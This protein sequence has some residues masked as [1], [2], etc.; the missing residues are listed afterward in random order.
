MCF[1]LGRAFTSV[2]FVLVL[3]VSVSS[4]MGFQACQVLYKMV[5]SGN[6]KKRDVAK[7]KRDGFIWHRHQSVNEKEKRNPPFPSWYR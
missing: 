4:P 2:L 5:L 3:L 7:K 1:L 6:I